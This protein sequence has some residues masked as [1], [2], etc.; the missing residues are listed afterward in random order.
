M[1]LAMNH[2]AWPYKIITLGD[3]GIDGAD[4]PMGKQGLPG[5]QGAPGRQ[6]DDGPM[7]EQGL[8]YLTVCRLHHIS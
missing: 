5:E 8:P 1:G 4:G 7:G 2:H 6:G 3:P